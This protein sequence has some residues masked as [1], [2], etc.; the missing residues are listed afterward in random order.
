VKLKIAVASDDRIHISSHFGRAAG[1]MVYQIDKGKIIS[2]EYRENTGKNKGKCGTC[3]H[4]AMILNVK[5]CKYVI[6]HGMG[7]RIYDD[8]S[9]NNIVAVVVEEIIVQ[10]ALQKFILNKLN[11]RIDKLH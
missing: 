9:A 2:T 1:F 3:D 11:N 7:K 10:D 5:D 6:S 4:N 8:L